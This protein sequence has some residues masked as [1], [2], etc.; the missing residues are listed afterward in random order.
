M[1]LIVVNHHFQ[2][3]KLDIQKHSF[4]TIQIF[5]KTSYNGSYFWTYFCVYIC[6]CVSQQVHV[7]INVEILDILSVNDKEFSITMSM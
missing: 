6:I 4:N 3:K 1:K 5:L 7:D 2:H